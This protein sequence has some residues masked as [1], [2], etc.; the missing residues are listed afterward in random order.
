M[1]VW[2]PLGCRY[3]PHAGEQATSQS[4][5]KEGEHPASYTQDNALEQQRGEELRLAAGA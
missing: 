2:S 5:S 1:W 3:T 4:Y